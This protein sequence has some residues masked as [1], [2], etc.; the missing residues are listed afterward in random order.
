MD[1]RSY[2]L[3]KPH[4]TKKRLKANLPFKFNFEFRN[5][6]LFSRCVSLQRREQPCLIESVMFHALISQNNAV[7]IL[8]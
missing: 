8:H 4:T 1:R 7:V 2:V 3:H 6:K 5:E